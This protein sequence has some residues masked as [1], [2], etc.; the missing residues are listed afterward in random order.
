[1]S[2]SSKSHLPGEDKGATLKCSQILTQDL[3]ARSS[4]PFWANCESTWL[5]ATEN[6]TTLVSYGRADGEQTGKV[7]RI[8]KSPVIRFIFLK[9]LSCL[10]YRLGPTSLHFYLFRWIWNSYLVSRMLGTMY[11]RSF[12]RVKSLRKLAT[13]SFLHT[14]NLH[15][16]KPI[17][18]S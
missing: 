14:M 7:C 13:T 11:F 12:I 1:M 10:C 18:Y 3:T 8:S 9:Y 15:Q 17:R 6:D 4:L 2:A 5:W 16:W